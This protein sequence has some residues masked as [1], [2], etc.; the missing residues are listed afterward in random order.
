MYFGAYRAPHSG[1]RLLGTDIWAPD[2]I[3]F[4]SILEWGWRSL[5]SPHLH[6]FDWAAGYPLASSLCAQDNLLGW[7]LFYSP[8]R[9]VGLDPVTAMNLIFGLSF[10]ISG[11]GAVALAR[12]YGITR[13]G[14]I[15]VGLIF[16][17]APFHIGHTPE[18]TSL[19]VCWIP[20]ALL[21]VEK[22]GAKGKWSDGL[23]ALVIACL[24][25]LSG[26]YMGIF[27]WITVFLSVLLR[28]VC[29]IQRISWGLIGRLALVWAGTLICLSPILLKY[30]QFVHS[31]GLFQSNTYTVWYKAA[32]SLRL[33]RIFVP[34]RFSAFWVHLVPGSNGVWPGITVS[35]LLIVGIWKGNKRWKLYSLFIGMLLL[36]LAGGPVLVIWRDPVRIAGHLVPMPG[37]VFQLLP[38]IRNPSRMALPALCFFALLSGTGADYLMARFRWIGLFLVGAL[39]IELFPVSSIVSKAVELPLPED[40]ADGYRHLGS[41]SASVELP[42]LGL[43]LPP[44]MLSRYIY[45]AAGHLHRVASYYVLGWPKEV[46]ALQEQATKLPSQVARAMLLANGVDCVI[47]HKVTLDYES[48]L[49]EFKQ[50]GYV[51][52]FEGSNSAIISLTVPRSDYR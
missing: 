36:V 7:Q 10:V 42:V 27:L 31:Y 23:A 16:A 12:H 2:N 48:Q 40:I 50:A 14:S 45:G 4:L 5:W 17:F 28:H 24:T 38:F 15:C 41:C 9:Y 20:V 6:F 51:M 37:L 43:P 26:V 1:H 29:A 13:L 30:V 25:T 34:S 22:F 3:L 8:M 52:A 11:L 39:I 44:E 19:A 47:L 21:F 46:L 32:H 33:A 35:V 49:D 18:I